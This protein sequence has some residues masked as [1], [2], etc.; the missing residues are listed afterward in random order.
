MTKEGHLFQTGHEI[1]KLAPQDPYFKRV[2][3]KTL[4]VVSFGIYK[5]EEK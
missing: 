3:L 2:A 4:S 5:Y 1:P